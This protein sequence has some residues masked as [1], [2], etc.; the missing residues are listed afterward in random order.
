MADLNLILFPAFIL[1][2]LITLILVIWSLMDNF[3]NKGRVAR[4]LNLVLFSVS[5]PK[6]INKGK[7]QQKPNKEIISVMEQFYA[8]SSAFREK[9]W[10]AFFYG[11]PYLVFE[12]AVPHI[13][14]EIKFY[15]AVPRHYEATMEKTIHGFYPEA[16][17]EKVNDYNIFNPE[18]ATA[19]AYLKLDK[20]FALPFKTYQNLEANPLN[21]IINS[22]SKLEEKGEGAAIQ[23]LIQPADKKW[24]K[25]VLKIIKE[26]REGKSFNE[27]RAKAG[28]GPFEKAV[29]EVSK[30]VISEKKSE[31][32][33][34]VQPLQEEIIKALEGKVNKIGFETNV[35]LIASASNE[36]R[37]KQ[38]LFQIKNS[39]NQFNAPTL[40]GIKINDASGNNLKKLIF[41]FSFRIFNPAE[42]MVLNTEELTSFYH[43]PSAGVEAPKVA[44]V[45][46][47]SAAPPVGLPKEG[48]IIGKNLYRGA[49]TIVRMT[50][51]D[52]RRHFYII[53]QTGTGKSSLLE[54]MIKQDI[55]AGRG[56]G[57]MDPHGSLIERVLSFVPKERAEDVVL[58]DPNDFERPFGMNMLEYDPSQPEQKSFIIDELILIFDKLYDLKT[59]GGP[60]FEQYMRNAL[61]LLMD[62]P[63]ESVT[64]VEVPRV[65]ADAEYRRYLLNK[66]K[67]IIT[68]DFWEKEAEKA[69]GEAALANM[70]PYITSKFNVFLVNDYMRP[71]IA[72]LKTT[73]NFRDIIDNKKILLVNLSS[74]KV[75]DINSSLLGLILVGKLW[76]AAR[77]RETS[78]EINDFFL[79]MD[80][81]QR[82]V[83]DTIGTILAEA[84]KFKLDLIMSHQFIKQLP[85]KI[86]AAVFGN[87]GS[88]LCFRI[89]VEDAP[90]MVKEFEPVFSESDLINIDNLN[91]YLKMLINGKTAPPFNI[92]FM[93]WS[94]GDPERAKLIKELARLKYGRPREGVEAD[95]A[96]RRVF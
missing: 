4:S 91:A 49:E 60:M 8:S 21:E 62:D 18:G 67:N 56:V 65:M 11:Q 55:E 93:G 70:V 53:G 64:L 32:E 12:L 26:M 80:E 61:Q 34:K 78:E 45:K 54:E 13:G 7:E 3:F 73:F 23:I 9:G 58:L 19:G 42:M 79:Y 38:I 89:G 40:N 47:K 77:S 41:N 20:N 48:I 71:I 90:I 86:S 14:E 30:A 36:I 16:V 74:A 66:C 82:F 88:K 31:K 25:Y 6:E 92:Q 69:G 43:F 10:R 96:K 28:R 81:F 37:A 75:G 72:Q 15:M 44:F 29:S 24:Q 63:N 39:F 87:A 94:K 68:K 95:I 46:A 84:R 27:A 17:V 33:Q 22:L 85:E 59:T 52:R 76:M 83:T 51:D 2:A 5:V 50:E 35:R 1:L 57:I